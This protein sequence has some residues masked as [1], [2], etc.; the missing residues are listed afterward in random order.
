[1][2]YSYEYKKQCVEMYRQGKWAETPTGITQESFRRMV[3]KRFGLERTVPDILDDWDVLLGPQVLGSFGMLFHPFPVLIKLI[4]AA[5]PLSIQVHPSNFYAMCREH[6]YGKTEMWYI[7]DAEPG[8]F[9]YYGFQH[10]ISKEEFAQ[11]IENNTL[12]EVLNA[13]PVQNRFTEKAEVW[14]P[15]E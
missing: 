4:D 5:Q 15:L 3:R 10:E 1:M 9:L 2:K 7:V 11:R 6:Q 12:T 13:V 8:A 14:L